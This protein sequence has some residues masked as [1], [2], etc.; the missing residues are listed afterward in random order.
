MRKIIILLL[1]ILTLSGY[2]HAYDLTAPTVPSEAAKFMPSTQD[3]LASGIL[4]VLRDA[5]MYIRPDLRE[6]TSVSIKIIVVVMF[7]SLLRTCT[8]SSAN[9]ANLIASLGISVILFESSNSL[10]NLASKTITEISEYGKL[11]LP[12]IT[13]A[14][15]GQGGVGTSAALYTSTALFDTILT[16]IIG[17]LLMPLIFLF[18]FLAIASG[19]IGDERLYKLRD[20]IKWSM[21]WTLKTILY[22]YTGYIGITGV[23]SGT[24][25][26]AALKATK[27]T[28]SG[29][30]PIVGGIMSDA[31]EA[32]LISAGTVKNAAGMYGLL[33]IL[34]IWIGPF[35]QIGIHYLLLKATASVCAI[36]SDKQCTSLIEDFSSAMGLLLAM[37]G[38]ICLILLISLVCF[39]R[40][41]G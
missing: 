34:A 3:N 14:L 40:G 39:L 13:A 12:V 41:V 5:L 1:V 16:T 8:G 30:V 26:A 10:I 23:V 28:I 11:L 17:K 33:A 29:M 37:T 36:F 38:A 2:V 6:A 7:V 19:A 24:T 31:S 35:M 25:D 21:T 9:T 15:A 32:I 4:E 27:L 18:L 20:T 22:V